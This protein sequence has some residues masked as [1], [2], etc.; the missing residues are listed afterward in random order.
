MT[1]SPDQRQ[2][3]GYQ[4][5]WQGTC[6]FSRPLILCNKQKVIDG[7]EVNGA[8]L[9]GFLPDRGLTKEGHAM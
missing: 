2:I 1:A 4:K 6:Q 5:Q 9:L 8:G 3:P 7:M